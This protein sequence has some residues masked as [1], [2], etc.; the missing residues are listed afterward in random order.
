MRPEVTL[1]SPEH[2]NLLDAELTLLRRRDGRRSGRE[3]R[4]PALVRRRERPVPPQRPPVLPADG[5]RAGLLAGI[6][7]RR[8]QRRCAAARGRADQ[9]ARLQ[10]RPHPPEG[11]GPAL[12]LLVRS[13]RPAGLGRDGQ[14]LRLLDRGR[15]SGS[16]ASGWRWSAATSAIPASSPGC[17]STRAGACSTSQAIRP[18]ASTCGR[19]LISPAR[20]TRRGRWSATTAGSTCASDILDHPRLHATTPTG[21]GSDMARGSAGAD[22]PRGPARLPPHLDDRRG[23]GRS[24]GHAHRVRR[25]QLRDRSGPTALGIQLGARRRLIP[26]G[27]RRARL[28]RA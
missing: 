13:A 22:D 6:A 21:S 14:R 17:R 5:A 18:S 3:L 26:R 9:G 27:I 15:S 1:W 11:R 16:P 25:H 4:R 8:A 28:G 20:S 24:A 2:P 10:R 7:P 12:P 19:S 23:P